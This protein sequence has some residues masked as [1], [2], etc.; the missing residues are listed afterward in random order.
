MW[1]AYS[2]LDSVI[3]DKHF[4]DFMNKITDKEE[5]KIHPNFAI[6]VY[7]MLQIRLSDRSKQRPVMR[8]KPHQRGKRPSNDR[9]GSNSFAK[10]SKYKR[11][12]SGIF[13]GCDWLSWEY[14]D[15]IGG[16][17]AGQYKYFSAK[18][19][20]NG[21]LAEQKIWNQNMGG[22]PVV[23][24][25]LLK[26]QEQ[27]WQILFDVAGLTDDNIKLIIDRK[28]SEEGDKA[29]AAV[30]KIYTYETNLYGGLN[31]ALQTKDK[32]KIKTFGPYACL[33]ER[34]LMFSGL[35]SPLTEI[36]D[37]ELEYKKH[38]ELSETDEVK[39]KKMTKVYRGCKLAQDD[40]KY[41]KDR[42]FD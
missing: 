21:I 13:D 11:A 41:F 30:L 23:R 36:N 19:V 7:K 8:G 27:G 32:S 39:D 9:L 12:G 20:L 40:I 37:K 1:K 6:N 33:L 2:D 26:S 24:D 4:F 3:I 14:Q 42:Q 25:E 28:E 31:Y 22:K 34:S 17:F 35:S 5:V 38:D 15:S 18:D 16:D 29:R 10:M